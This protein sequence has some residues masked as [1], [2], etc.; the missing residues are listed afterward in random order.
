VLDEDGEIVD[1]R[2][3]RAIDP[4]WPAMR[5]R[6]SREDRLAVA[7]AGNRTNAWGKNDW[8]RL[9][10]LVEQ[11][12]N[13]QS[14]SRV[15]A[16]VALREDANRSDREIARL[17]GA[18]P[19]T[20]TAVRRDLEETA[21]LEQFT[22]SVGGRPRAD[23]TPA[24]PRNNP[25][26]QTRQAEVVRRREAGESWPAIGVATGYRDPADVFRRV[27]GARDRE[28]ARRQSE[29]PE[30]RCTHCPEHCPVPDGHE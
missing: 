13:R 5:L 26:V 14:A 22:R 30:D 25:D 27:T 11:R 12:Q 29:S 8:Q 16:E 15:L 19:Q 21:Q 20:V 28:P 18:S 1:G 24:Q 2:H 23:G 3:R 9:R 10:G 7:V 6:V 4:G 17:T